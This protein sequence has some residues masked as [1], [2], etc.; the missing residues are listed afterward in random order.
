MI[1]NVG[2]T[3]ELLEVRRV[4]N[5]KFNIVEKIKKNIVQKKKQEEKY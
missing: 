2:G 4:C 5:K 3:D 1:S